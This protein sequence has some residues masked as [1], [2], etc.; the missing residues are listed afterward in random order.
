MNKQLKNTKALL[1]P[2]LAVIILIGMCIGV[3]NF[4]WG[5]INTVNRQIADAEQKNAILSSRLTTLQ[6]IRDDVSGNVNVAS[7]AVPPQNPSI[8]VTNVL[9]TSA[10]ENSVALSH[11]SIIA[12]SSNTPAEGAVQDPLA[13]DLYEVTFEA[14]AESY[15]SLSTFIN[16]LSNTKPLLTLTSVVVEKVTSGTGVVAQVK[17]NAYSSPFPSELPALDQPLSSLSQEEEEILAILETY[18]APAISTS[19]TPATEVPPRDDP[20]SLGL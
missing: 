16:S 17:L 6:E 12:I 9:K 7:I 4:L 20:F 11:L 19:E 8:L 3:F 1:F 18:K 14:A 5:R 15:S 2:L 10:A 13:V